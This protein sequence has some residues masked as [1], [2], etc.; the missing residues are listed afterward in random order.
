MESSDL[1]T[2]V[3]ASTLTV[4]SAETSHSIVHSATPVRVFGTTRLA[5]PP[6]CVR[7]PVSSPT[8]AT[9]SST[10]SLPTRMSFSSRSQVPGTLRPALMEVLA[11]GGFGKRGILLS[12]RGAAGRLLN[13]PCYSGLLLK[14]GALY[15]S[16]LQE[17]DGLTTPV[18][19]Q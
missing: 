14:A 8:A 1:L 16:F 15:E 6:P 5:R 12:I 4:G 10:P 3:G 18:L 9:R 7:S 19:V 17:Q 13:L 11:L 2:S